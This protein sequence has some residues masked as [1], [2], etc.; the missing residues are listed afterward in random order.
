MEVKQRLTFRF[1][2]SVRQAQQLAREF[3]CARWVYDKGLQLRKECYKAQHTM[4]YC[5]TSKA[6]T[7]WRNDPHT[8]WLQRASHVTKQQ[9]LRALDVGYKNFFAKR[10]ELPKVKKNRGTQS[11]SYVGKSPVRWDP[12]NHNLTI[13]KV[14]RLKV[15]WSREFTS[16]PSTVTIT[17]DCAG[18][19]FVTLCLDEVK[20]ALPKTGRQVGID[21]GINRL[22]TLSTG[23]RI[24]N[25]RHTQHREKKLASLQRVLSRRV[26]GSGR[27]KRQ[28]MK[29]AKLYSRVAD[30]RK[31]FLDKIT[32]DLVRKYDVL[33]IEDLNV[34]GMLKNRC[35]AKHI[36]CAA[37][38]MF[39][40]MLIYKCAWYG[41][42]LRVA[43]RFFPS[44]KRC[45]SC[46]HIHDKMPLNIREFD[47]ESCGQNHDRDENAA[48]NILQF[49]KPTAGGQPVEAH[50][51]KVGL[52]SAKAVKSTSRRSVNQPALCPA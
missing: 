42:D 46:G 47:C 27:W 9:A 20:H 43:D 23:D 26:K 36:S 28:K 3:G 8:A 13:S 41:K 38:R 5:G 21:L 49:G 33:A 24:E 16:S 14:G 15:R 45:H 52:G 10:A 11:V 31:D 30:S 37:F 7:S 35:L 40:Q 25:P 19:Y 4:G 1:Y 34:S 22:A 32:T 29:V 44:T 12:L 18:R 48:H 17:K 50:G 39:R 6:L 2:P 51:G